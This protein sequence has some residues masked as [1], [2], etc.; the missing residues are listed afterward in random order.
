MTDRPLVSV[1]NRERRPVN[2]L[3]AREQFS[4]RYHAALLEYLEAADEG[5]LLGGY[6]LGRRALGDGL[7]VLDMATIHSDAVATLSI[8]PR[9]GEERA[10]MID[11]ETA[12]F[13]E[14]LSP[15]EMAHRAFR[16]ANAML[17]GLNGMLERQAKQIAYAL[18]N[19]AGQLLASVHFALGEAGRELPPEKVPHLAKVREL[20]IEIEDRLRNLSHELRPPVLDDLG[21]PAALDLLADGV[22]KRWGLPVAVSASL[23][24]DVPA[25]IEN[26]V[27][28]I[29]QEALTNAAKHAGASCAE[30]DLRQVNHKIVCSIRDDGVGFD[31]TA[32]FR[33]R[34]PGLGLTE[35]R[36]RVAAL[37]G[38]VRLGLNNERGTDLTI[39][40]PL[41]M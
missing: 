9:G 2:N 39:E 5:G 27:Y 16:D 12:F 19:E 14:A 37:G 20:L 36:E 15:F 4:E 31:G 7:G 32:G 33:K 29:T 40:I 23:N 17:R 8:A 22:S 6:E 21:L 25:S 10:P 1:A 41:E 26:T 13:V 11:A 34:R 35:I 30:V 18:H 28:R 24:G 3:T 38:I